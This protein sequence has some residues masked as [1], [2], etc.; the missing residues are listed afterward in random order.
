MKISTWIASTGIA[1]TL[2]AALLSLT[3]VSFKLANFLE[4]QANFSFNLALQGWM[5]VVLVA[6]IY[7]VIRY[8]F[9]MDFVL[10]KRSSTK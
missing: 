7:V 1:V 6:V 4:I 8:V 3:I 9:K 5:F 10:Q 2:V